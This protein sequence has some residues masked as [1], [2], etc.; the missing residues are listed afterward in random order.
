LINP[1]AVAA[2]DAYDH[3]VL[4][5]EKVHLRARRD[6]DVAVLHADLYD[7]VDTRSRADSRPWRPRPATSDSPYAPSVPP[8]PDDA[9]IFTI[10]TRDTDEVGGEG[11]LWGIDLHNRLAHVGVSLRPA[12]RGRGL[13][14]DTVRVLCRYGFV[15]RGFHR[16]QVDTLADNHP[17]IRAAQRSGFVLEGTMRRSAWVLGEFVDEVVLGLLAEDWQDSQDGQDA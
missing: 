10:V 7:D 3:R 13:G 9:A 6:E 2:G 17:M 12:M 1:G 14:G 15:V 4:T 16:L 5:G 11:L 8:A